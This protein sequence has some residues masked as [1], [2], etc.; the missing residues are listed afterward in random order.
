[1]RFSVEVFFFFGK[2]RQEA[3]DRE[4]DKMIEWKNI[5]MNKK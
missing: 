4:G 5:Y 3:R 2:D 1:M